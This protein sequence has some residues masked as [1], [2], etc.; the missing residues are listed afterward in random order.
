MSLYLDASVIVP[1]FVEEP[2]GRAIRALLEERSAALVVSEFAAAEVASAL[3]RL[4]RMGLASESGALA[5][6]SEFDEWRRLTTREIETDTADLRVAS[7]LARRFA[8]RLRAPDALH[9]AL[10]RRGGHTLVT[11]DKRLAAAA[12]AIGV[13]ATVPG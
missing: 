13:V 11:L 6:L 3:G 4:A 8:L 5:R 7:A 9:L 12:D 2:A 10:C 1:L